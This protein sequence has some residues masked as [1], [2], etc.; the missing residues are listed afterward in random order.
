ML[1]FLGNAFTKNYTAIFILY[2]FCESEILHSKRF[3]T[4]D[5]NWDMYFLIFNNFNVI[6]LFKPTFCN[7]RRKTKRKTL[8]VT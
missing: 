3:F 7:N 1:C 8:S 2:Y 4:K 5:H 6:Q